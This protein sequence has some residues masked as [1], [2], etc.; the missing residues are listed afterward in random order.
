M[1][2]IDYEILPGRGGDNARKALEKAVENGFSAEDVQT[3]R[4]GY[5]IPV[6]VDELESAGEA[7][8]SS[9]KGFEGEGLTPASHSLTGSTHKLAGQGSGEQEAFD[10]DK[11]SV[12]ELD[13]HID[14]KKLDVD[15]SLNK[16]EKVAAIKAATA[17]KGD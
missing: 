13:D 16:P 14:T 17:N 9:P 10:V 11:A 15:K 4:G 12:K 8:E 2:P 7:S 6:E 1:A 5:R 3:F